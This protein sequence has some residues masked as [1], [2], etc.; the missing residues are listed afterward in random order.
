MPDRQ[1]LVGLGRNRGWTPPLIEALINTKSVASVNFLK[2]VTGKICHNSSLLL[3]ITLYYYITRQVTL[4]A[5]NCNPKDTGLT[6]V[7]TYVL[8]HT[9]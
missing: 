8:V 7:K 9:V 5:G 4:G 1:N 6:K 3:H 2:D